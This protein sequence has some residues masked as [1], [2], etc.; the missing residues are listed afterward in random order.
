MYRHKKVGDSILVDLGSTMKVL[1]SVAVNGDMTNINP[2]S[3]GK[4][5][6]CESFQIEPSFTAGYSSPGRVGVALPKLGIDDNISVT[7]NGI[8]TAGTIGMDAVNMTKILP[9]VALEGSTPWA[10][11]AT[12]SLGNIYY[13]PIANSA[14]DKVSVN[15][16]VLL[17]DL[18]YGMSLKDKGVAFGFEFQ[19]SS[20]ATKNMSNIKGSITARYNYSPIRTLDMEV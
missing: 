5:N 7:L 17:A 9:F 1:S 3:N 19:T 13:L 12:L 20:S 8:C 2:A 18:G 15:Y 10:G 4:A 16:Q 6:I 11:G 14:N